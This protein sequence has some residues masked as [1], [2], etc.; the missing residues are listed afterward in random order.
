[1]VQGYAQ[2]SQRWPAQP[3]LQ[4][5]QCSRRR[6][7][8]TAFAAAA[9]RT[10]RQLKNTCA[11]QYAALERSGARWPS[12]TNVNKHRPEAGALDGTSSG[13][14]EAG[15]SAALVHEIKPRCRRLMRTLQKRLR[16]PAL[17]SLRVALDHPFRLGG[18]IASTKGERGGSAAR[19][20]R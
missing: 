10:I 7:D 12:S 15:Q 3:L 4:A 18:G 2:T 1:V 17:G 13:Q 11:E 5:S 8:Q 14:V 9:R 19:L 20:T 6:V 16:R